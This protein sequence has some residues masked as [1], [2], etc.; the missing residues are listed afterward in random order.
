MTSLAFAAIMH[1][2][3]LAGG[4]NYDEAYRLAAETGQPLVVLVGAEWCPACQGMKQTVVPQLVRRGSLKK[5]SFAAVNTDRQSGLAGKL[6]RAS[7]IPQLIMYVK[8]DKGWSRREMIGL[9][10]VS[11]IEEF[12]DQGVEMSARPSTVREVKVAQD[13]SVAQ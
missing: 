7:S 10:S 12:L 6:M 1:C 2:S 8:T 5:V 4:Q 13:E 11:A 3:V 9:Q